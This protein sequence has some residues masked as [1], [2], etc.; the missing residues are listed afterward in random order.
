MQE[1]INT[2]PWPPLKP[3]GND[4]AFVHI[5]R[6]KYFFRFFPVPVCCGDFHVVNLIQQGYYQAPRQTSVR[7]FKDD[8][9][10]LR[11]CSLLGVTAAICGKPLGSYNPGQGS[12][13]GDYCAIC[14]M[15]SD[16]GTGL[17]LVLRVSPFTY[18]SI[19]EPYPHSYIY[20]VCYVDAYWE[21][22]KV[23]HKE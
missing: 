9:G 23:K 18:H 22:C 1:Y 14:H 21:S 6:D 19:K 17:L 2:C 8:N 16:T 10:R 4:P 15:Y 5:S 3:E 11:R 7:L 12:K 20:H 13:S